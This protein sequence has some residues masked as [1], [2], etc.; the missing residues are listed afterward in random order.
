MHIVVRKICF[1]LVLLA[2]WVLSSQAAAEAKTSLKP[3]IYKAVI[4]RADGQQIIFNF[5][6]KPLNGKTVLYV[7]N[8][9]ER[10]LVDDIRQKAILSGSRCLS[11]MPILPR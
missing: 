2:S 7:L 10:M 8:A 6:V 11:M 3:G 1:S 9:T 5:E 4:H